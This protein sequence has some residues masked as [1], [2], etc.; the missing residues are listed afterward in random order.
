MLFYILFKK[1]ERM[2]QK[3]VNTLGV[4]LA[5]ILFIACG[6]SSSDTSK[7][8][9]SQ[10]VL[11]DGSIDYVDYKGETRNAGDSA[12]KAEY[13]TGQGFGNTLFGSAEKK[14][15]NCHNEL[16]DTWESSMH[17]QSWKDKVFQGK[18]Q[19]FFRVHMAKIG[20]DKTA[21]GG[22]EYTEAVFVKGASH[23]CIKCHAPGAYYA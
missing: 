20:E 1:G 22:K 8:L 21:V 12:A 6:G 9:G 15:Q 19:D 10:N 3:F 18:M 23:T 16:Y 7:A 2:K 5:M 14:C 11:A 13:H 17:G 4:I